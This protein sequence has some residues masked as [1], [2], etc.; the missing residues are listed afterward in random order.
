MERI[1]CNLNKQLQDMLQNA[2]FTD[3][4]IADRLL[5]LQRTEVEDEREGLNN[6]G[7]D[8]LIIQRVMLTEVPNVAN[9]MAH[10][11]KSLTSNLDPA[12]EVFQVDGNSACID[13][14]VKRTHKV[15]VGDNLL[16]EYD[17]NT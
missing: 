12:G 16:N 5:K 1:T 17:D 7:C 9:P 2:F 15:R 13:D 10:V 8:E 4:R 14:E 3:S 6:V 11:L